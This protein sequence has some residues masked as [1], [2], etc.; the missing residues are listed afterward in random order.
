MF[1]CYCRCGKATL[2]QYGFLWNVMEE[3]LN[4]TN[5]KLLQNHSLDSLLNICIKYLRKPSV[6]AL[7]VDT[8]DYRMNSSKSSEDHSALSQM[9]T[10]WEPKGSYQC[11]TDV[12]FPKVGSEFIGETLDLGHTKNPQISISEDT[13]VR[14]T[15]ISYS[16]RIEISGGF[17]GVGTIGVSLQVIHKEQMDNAVIDFLKNAI[18]NTCKQIFLQL[19]EDHVCSNVTRSNVIKD[20]C[21]S[22]TNCS[23]LVENDDAKI[24]DGEQL[25]C[26]KR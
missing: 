26:E 11:I 25:F 22:E 10:S 14:N 5:I 21:L 18:T 15:D 24:G 12:P 20:S 23:Q 8:S 6:S 13:T 1:C 2:E 9:E 19:E 17:N 4:G 7:V 16:K 3:N